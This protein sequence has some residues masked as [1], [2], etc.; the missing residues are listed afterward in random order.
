[1]QGCSWGIAAGARGQRR[2][3]R[4]ALRALLLG[5]HHAELGL[6]CRDRE[7]PHRTRAYER[8]DPQADHRR[9]AAA[10]AAAAAGR[11][12]LQAGAHALELLQIVGVEVDAWLG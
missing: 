4:L 6:A 5:Q 7:Q 10:A 9:D 8:V 12:V 1:M 11:H 2:H 3:H